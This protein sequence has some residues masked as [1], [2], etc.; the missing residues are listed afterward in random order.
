[1]AKGEA[2]SAGAEREPEVD[3]PDKINPAVYNDPQ[4]T[5]RLV[6]VLKQAL[7]EES[8]LEAKR[9][10][11]QQEH[12]RRKNAAAAAAQDLKAGASEA[13]TDLRQSREKAVAEFK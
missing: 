9:Q 12:D 1:M 11:A 3:V 13:H 2:L 8:A 5:M 6:A 4:V 7:G 10:A